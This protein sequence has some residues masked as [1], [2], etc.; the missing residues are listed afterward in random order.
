M[1]S[2][3]QPTLSRLGLTLD[4]SLDSS[5]AVTDLFYPAG[6]LSSHRDSRLDSEDGSQPAPRGEH[7]PRGPSEDYFNFKP[8]RENVIVF[9]VCSPISLEKGAEM[10]TS[11]GQSSDSEAIICELRALVDRQ[12]LEIAI[13]KAN[14]AAT[15]LD[16]ATMTTQM[17]EFKLVPA[18]KREI[19]HLTNACKRYE[20]QNQELR[21]EIQHCSSDLADL[22]HAKARLSKELKKYQQKSD[23]LEAEFRKI[24]EFVDTVLNRAEEQGLGETDMRHL[25]NYVSSKVEIIGSKYS[26]LLAAYDR[27]I[28][29]NAKLREDLEGNGEELAKQLNS[30]ILLKDKFIEKL[31]K[32]LVLYKEKMMDLKG[33][34]D[35][36]QF[37]DLMSK[38]RT[39]NL[40]HKLREIA[41]DLP[42]FRSQHGSP[43]RPVHFSPEPSF[44]FLDA[45]PVP[46]ELL[47]EIK[48]ETPVK[49]K[50]LAWK[51]KQTR[52]HAFI[53]TNFQSQLAV[54]KYRPVL[55]REKSG[56]R[57]KP[58]RTD[59]QTPKF[60][61]Q[62]ESK[63]VSV[64]RKKKDLKSARPS[65]VPA[66]K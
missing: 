43:Q 32:T 6:S 46:A 45:S 22:D 26:R 60:C 30:K 37:E 42:P 58:A 31:E 52:R 40:S 5:S 17:E 63:A 55:S 61:R 28:E 19:E 51:N 16:K 54:E 21:A 33:E 41:E 29:E 7:G 36:E 59:S 57:G 14:T 48:Q 4:L 27:A 50:R 3:S 47:A 11:L 13:L 39:E 1:K 49:E 25:S 53:G 2:D 23:S 15:S 18:L 64:E 12:R 44:S 38:N 65:H 9:E 62:P 35:S 8:T 24:A 20:R 66:P 34:E 56:S 10:R